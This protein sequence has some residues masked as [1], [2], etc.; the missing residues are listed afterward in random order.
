MLWEYDRDGRI[1][2]DNFF[3]REPELSM[4]MA[5][6]I[7]PKRIRRDL[8]AFLGRLSAAEPIGSRRPRGL[9]DQLCEIDL[10]TASMSLAGEGLRF[11]VLVFVL[12]LNLLLLLWGLMLLKACRSLRQR[13]GKDY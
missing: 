9:V 6:G 12:G 3:R 2:I 13:C 10:A 7:I 4:R 8:M 5:G 1:A 11:L